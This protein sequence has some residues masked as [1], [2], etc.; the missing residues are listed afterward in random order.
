MNELKRELSK[1]TGIDFFNPKFREVF[2]KHFPNERDAEEEKVDEILDDNKDE[3]VDDTEA[4]DF[5]KDMKDINTKEADEKV[6]SKVE[7][8]DKAEDEREIDKIE[9][10]K[11]ESPEIA[12]EKAEEVN[13]ESHEIGKSVNELEDS[14]KQL[15][16]AKIELELIR[17]GVSSERLESAKRMA[18]Y[19]I[20]SLDEL[21]KVKDLIREYPEWVRSFKPKDFGMAVDENAD[22][23]TEEEKKLKQMGI[24]PR[25]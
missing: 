20:G 7:D 24:N 12:D 19:E 3:K 21:Y 1:L 4:E 9:E 14:K 2:K 15:L 25:D 23:L 17:N 8:I 18:K 22:D 5:V 16:D 10:E 11:A 6:E 13:E